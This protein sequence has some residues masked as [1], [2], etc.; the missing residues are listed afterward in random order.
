MPETI[1][2]A[3][4]VH[5]SSP[6]SSPQTAIHSR[7]AEILARHQAHK[8]QTPIAAHSHALWPQIA[9][10]AARYESLVMDLGC[11]CGESTQ[12]L[13]RLHPHAAV[14]G[15][16]RSSVRLHKA[17]RFAPSNSLILRADQFDMLRLMQLH[18]LRAAKVYLL[19]PNPSPKP[20]HLKRRWHAHP[21]WPTLIA[22]TD[23]LELRTNWSIYADEFV[24]A[25]GLQQWAVVRNPVFVDH[26][27]A[28][29]S[30]FEAKYAGSGHA[31]WQ[32]LARR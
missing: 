22:V 4:K 13:A 10:F 28:A 30:L 1:E 2:L 25:L 9:A 17:P 6:V 16:D 23:Q 12:N 24:F 11:G 31:L 27:H 14:V 15:V 8:D 26:H 29:L 20:E 18:H 7:L 19:Y 21:I 5:K 3:A 32:V